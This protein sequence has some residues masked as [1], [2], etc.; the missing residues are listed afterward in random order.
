MLEMLIVLLFFFLPNPFQFFL[1]S[2]FTVHLHYC[3]RKVL[4]NVGCL[5]HSALGTT[6]HFYHGLRHMPVKHSLSATLNCSTN[7]IWRHS[8][9][10]KSWR[11]HCLLLVVSIVT[12]G[13]VLIVENML[14]YSTLPIYGAFPLG[15]CQSVTLL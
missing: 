5:R 14:K 9:K 6:P 4:L 1:C 7:Q 8:H 2:F 15:Q 10:T 3:Y 13:M 11:L 12:L